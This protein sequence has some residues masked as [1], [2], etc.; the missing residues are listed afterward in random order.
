VTDV[1]PLELE[2]H[3]FL[4]CYSVQEKEFFAEVRGAP[5][6]ASDRQKV[7]G[8]IHRSPHSKMCKLALQVS[9]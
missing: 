7:A 9:L 6:R 5:S 4:L 3:R 2:I 1:A 8:G